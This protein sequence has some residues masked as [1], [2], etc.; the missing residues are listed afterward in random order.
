MVY[1]DIIADAD[2]D[3]G[4][5]FELDLEIY[6]DPM[7]RPMTRQ[8]IQRVV[9]GTHSVVLVFSNRRSKG[10]VKKMDDT[11][12]TI[13][14]KLLVGYPMSKAF[15]LRSSRMEFSYIPKRGVLISDDRNTALVDHLGLQKINAAIRVKH[16]LDRVERAKFLAPGMDRLRS[17]AIQLSCAMY[18]AKFGVDYLLD[19]TGRGPLA[20]TPE[21]YSQV[22]AELMEEPDYYDSFRHDADRLFMKVR[23]LLGLDGQLYPYVYAVFY[24]LLKTKPNL[25]NLPLAK[26]NDEMLFVR[27]TWNTNFGRA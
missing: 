22:M 5:D 15:T 13:I 19:K 23:D 24:S 11:E 18:V 20:L 4:G 2:P 25:F 17:N 6:R 3:H 1:R 26:W 27:G 16:Y 9:A 12:M 8:R 7:N 10:S 21:R 14:A